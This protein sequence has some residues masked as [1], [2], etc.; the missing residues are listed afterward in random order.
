MRFFLTVLLDASLLLPAAHSSVMAVGPGAFPAGSPLLTFNGLATG[1]EVN[2]LVVSGVTFSY[3]I[4]GT[5]TNGLVEIDQ[6]PGPTNNIDPPNIVSL[7]PGDPSGMLGVTLPAS[8][9]LFGYGFAI[10]NHDLVANATTI[11]LFMGSTPV[12]SLSYSGAPDPD[13]TGGFVGIQSTIP[14][15][16][17]EL[18]FNSVAAVAFAVDNVTYSPVP[19]PATA[20]MVLAALALVC[21]ACKQRRFSGV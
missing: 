1:T 15:N 7:F 10:F 3:T 21:A 2:G 17:A 20:R 13:F 12:G 5:P 8:E 18:T 9:T 11:S 14:F 6:G 19:E 16:R 4:D